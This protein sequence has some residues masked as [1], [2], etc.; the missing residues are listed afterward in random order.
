MKGWE[1]EL[2]VQHKRLPTDTCMAGRSKGSPGQHCAAGG[3]PGRGREGGRGREEEVVR[4]GEVA[5][6]SKKYMAKI[7]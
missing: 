3:E 6:F 5:T 4:K 7:L 2:L 1:V